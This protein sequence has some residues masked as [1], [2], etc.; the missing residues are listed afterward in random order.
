MRATTA[1]RAV[2]G[3]L[4]ATALGG[5]SQAEDAV[6]KATDKAACAAAEKAM[7]RA[8]DVAGS[9]VDR[10]DADPAAARQQ[11]T[12]ARDAVAAAA[13]SGLPE[14]A[15]GALEEARSALNSL[16]D[17]AAQSAK[18]EVDQA[19]V[20]KSRDRLEDAVAG[21]GDAC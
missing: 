12:A 9:A 1:R 10:I 3:I 21:L 4:L 18:G 5:C 8:G 16:V 6:G 20:E 2:A 17:Q 11:L 14:Q 19:Q 13:D 7:E 15:R